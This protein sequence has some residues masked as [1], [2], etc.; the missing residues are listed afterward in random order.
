MN[1]N[2]KDNGWTEAGDKLSKT[3]SFPNFRDAM[4]WMMKVSYIF[5]KMD[6]HPEWTNEYNKVHVSLTTHSAGKKITEK[7]L[8]AA[9]LIDKTL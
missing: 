6:H 4:S 9:E 5:D 1:W 8:K 7:D 3:F 2:P